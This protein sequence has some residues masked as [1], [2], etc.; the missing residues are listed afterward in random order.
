MIFLFLIRATRQ[1]HPFLNDNGT[2]SGDDETP[3]ANKMMFV[4]RF[5]RAIIPQSNRTKRQMSPD[6]EQLCQVRS[7]YIN[8]Q[9]ALNVKGNWMYIVN[10]GEAATQLVRTEICL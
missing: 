8:P 1:I 9:A 4:N 5:L 10:G 3:E 6:R 2:I 7:S